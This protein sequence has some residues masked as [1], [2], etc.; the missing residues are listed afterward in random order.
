MLA[1]PLRPLI[2]WSDDHLYDWDLGT[3]VPDLFELLFTEP[4][5]LLD[6]ITH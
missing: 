4:D 5:D 3:D 2:P 6:S 1:L